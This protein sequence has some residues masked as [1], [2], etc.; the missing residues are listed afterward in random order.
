MRNT[1]HNQSNIK[2]TMTR[3]MS[4]FS[5]LSFL[6]LVTFLISHFSTLIS[7]AVAQEQTL[8]VSP[9]IINVTLSPGKTH[10]HKVTIENRSTMPMPLRA[11]LS[12]FMTGGEEGGY[13]FEETKDNP[14][15]SW[16]QLNESEFIL[17]PQEK[18]TIDMTITTPK[19]I[20]VG[21]YYGVLFFEPVVQGE[22]INVTKVN[23]KVGVLMLANI[24][25]PDANAQ[26]G[27]ILDF[28]TDFFQEDGTVPFMLRVKNTSLNFFSAKPNL[29]IAPLLSFTG[30]QKHY[31][32]EEKTIFP[33][34]I[35]RWTEET[36]VQD[37]QPNIYKATIAVSTG[38]GQTINQEQFFI[39]F[40][41]AQ[42]LLA[43]AIIMIVLFLSIKRGRLRKA[44]KELFKK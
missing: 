34:N 25:V 2:R 9:A 8:R 13:I 22:Q 42:A 14:L 39:V 21:G 5:C 30:A 41:I 33:S 26:K 44:A 11:T 17:N 36:T 16:I 6:L 12:D 4:F 1:I 37:L 23:A 7:P 43:A 10:T 20:P 35:R 27:E 15:L 40:P 24:G 3:V 19:S 28:S 31:E 32:L 38:N 18:K 29:T